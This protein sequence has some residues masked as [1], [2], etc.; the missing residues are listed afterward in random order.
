MPLSVILACAWVLAATVVALL[1]MRMQFPPGIALLIAAPVVIV[2]LGVDYNWFLSLAATAAFVSMYRN[3]LR[4]YW[5]K[6]FGSDDEEG[7]E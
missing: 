2:W 6:W 7:R 1:P 4:Y 3:P 5:R